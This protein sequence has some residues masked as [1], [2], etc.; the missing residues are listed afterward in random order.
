MQ[1]QRPKLKVFGKDGKSVTTIVS[2]VP[3][4]LAVHGTLK[5]SSFL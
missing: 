2:D 5:E 4:L 1:V 3:G